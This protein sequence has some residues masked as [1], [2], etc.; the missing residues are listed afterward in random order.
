VAG[1]CKQV[2]TDWLLSK[3][4]KAAA[5]AA[6]GNDAKKPRMDGQL[7]VCPVSGGGQ[8]GRSG[9]KS[10]QPVMKGRKANQQIPKKK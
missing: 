3:K 7:A 4:R 2:I 1:R 5:M 6:A 9:R 10:N 8:A